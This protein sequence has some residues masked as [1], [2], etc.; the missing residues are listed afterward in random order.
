MAIYLP[1]L[2]PVNTHFPVAETA[3]DDPNGLLAFGGDL[4]PERLVT[5]IA[6]AFSPGIRKENLFSGGVLRRVLSSCPISSG[7]A[8]VC[9]SSSANQGIKSH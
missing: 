1:E 9:A 6:K 7:Q 2:D 4:R 8:K 3:L 5:L